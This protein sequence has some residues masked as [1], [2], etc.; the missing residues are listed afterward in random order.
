M[1]LIRSFERLGK[2]DA[3][4]AGGKGASLG[5]MT[6][7]GIPVPPGFVVLATAFERFLE[8]ANLEQELDTIFHTVN[9][10]EIR[11]VDLAAERIQSLIVRAR[12]P[13][14]IADEILASFKT[15]GT[16][17]VAVRSSATAEDSQSAAWAGQLD[18]FLNT[19]QET[20]LQNVQKCWASLFTPRAIFYRFEKG[21]HGSKISVA[22][23]VQ[24]MVQSEVSGIAFSVHPVTEDYNQLIIEAGFGLGEAIVSGQV[25]PDSFVIEKEPRRLL[26]KNI[27]YQSKAL[28]RAASGGNEWRELSH[29]EGTKPA[30]SDEQALHL[31][32][33]VLRIEK[34]YGFPCDIEWA[35]EAGQYYITQSRPITTL[36]QKV[37]AEPQL[38]APSADADIVARI[39]E[40]DWQQDWNGL[41]TFTEAWLDNQKDTGTYFDAFE[42]AFGRSFSKV[43]ITYKGDMATGWVSTKENEELGT[44]LAER[45][46]D[47][48][49]RKV[50][51]K[52]YR[53]KADSLRELISLK[54]DDFLQRFTEFRQLYPSYGPYVIGT[55][56]AFN[57]LPLGTEDIAHELE[58][59]RKCTEQI[60]KISTKLFSELASHISEKTGY[61]AAS[62]RALNIEELENYAKNQTLP[63]EHI[64]QER[65]MSGG[66]YAES[67]SVQLISR[68]AVNELEKH[69]YK[70]MSDSE[71]HGATGYPGVVKGRSRIIKDYRS[72]SLEAGE[73]LVTAMTDPNFLPLMHKCAAII[74]DGGGM[75]SH[76]AIV[77]RELKKPCVIGTKFAT[78]VLKDGDMVEVDADNGIVRKL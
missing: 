56:M 42:R 23:V 60:Y 8:E 27:T 3:G 72:A 20:L 4:I 15:L 24:K 10:Q 1:E 21:M 55:K 14:D 57:F 34:H 53:D 9:Q 70:D 77:A 75:L 51:L 69:W 49:M 19:T 17:Y 33:I 61:D 31:A 28:W 18:T 68:N 36:S 41:Y 25:T 43:L 58:D 5:E 59:A 62:I 45:I 11:S 12:I 66:V 40:V 54:P 63:D 32:E 48:S 78:Q 65:A 30:L 67:N 37:N 29:E 39:K 76:A 6:Q 38:L 71:L 47:A 22:V 52:T 44:Y 7:A 13:Q 26:D 73:V 64:L 16:T 50:W 2:G 74:T 46:Q 35:F